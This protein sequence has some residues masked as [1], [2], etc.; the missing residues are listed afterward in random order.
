LEAVWGEKERYELM[1][2]VV[3]KAV[4]FAKEKYMKL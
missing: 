1:M 4:E 2:V 3:K